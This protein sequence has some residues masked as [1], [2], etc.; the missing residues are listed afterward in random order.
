MVI[1]GVDGDC[2]RNSGTGEAWQETVP[3]LKGQGR[4]EHIYFPSVRKC[5]FIFQK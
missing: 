4:G 3:V 2:D 5:T 1:D